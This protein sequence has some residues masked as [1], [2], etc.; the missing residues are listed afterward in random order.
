MQ[1]VNIDKKYMDSIKKIEI[2]IPD[3][4]YGK[5]AYKPFFGELFKLEDIAYVTQI[6]SPKIKHDKMKDNK[7]FKKIIDKNN[8]S[9]LGVVNLNYMFPVPNKLYNY[10]D[11]YDI[12]KY[13]KFENDLQKFKYINLLIKE[14]KIINEEKIDISAKKLY[15]FVKLNKE[16]YIAKRCFDFIRLN[17]FAK[18]YIDKALNLNNVKNKDIER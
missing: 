16:S 6:S 15:D 1:L 10:I 17:E 2:R 8:N 5:N 3:Y 7:D 4:N 14:L 12:E 11:P 13:R 18:K 9:L